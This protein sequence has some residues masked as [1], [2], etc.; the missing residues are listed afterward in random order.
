MYYYLRA[1]VVRTGD[2]L[3]MEIGMEGSYC[4]LRQ[5]C[6]SVDNEGVDGNVLFC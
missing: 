4:L 5:M 6:V 1:K 2:G 3:E